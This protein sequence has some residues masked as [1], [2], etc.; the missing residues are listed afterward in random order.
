[1]DPVNGAPQKW[2]QNCFFMCAYATALQTILC[3]TIP[4]VLGGKAKKGNVEGDMEYE[5][6]NTGLATVLTI[7]RFGITFCMYMATWAV[8]IQFLMCLFVGLAAWIRGDDSKVECDADGTPKW[9]PANPILVYVALGLKW[10]TF[11]FL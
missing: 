7:I 2:A 9:E 8:L 1:M 3:V 5:V 4:V 6:N 11:V 10:L